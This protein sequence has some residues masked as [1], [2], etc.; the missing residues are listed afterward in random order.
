V[1]LL[2]ELK[3]MKTSEEHYAISRRF[4][5]ALPRVAALKVG[6]DTYEAAHEPDDSLLPAKQE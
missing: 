5:Q 4:S 2:N 3:S 6:Y 1:R